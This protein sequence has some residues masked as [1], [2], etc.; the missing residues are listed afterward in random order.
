MPEYL[1]VYGTLRR[2]TGSEMHRLLAR[3]ADL[4]GGAS[5]QGQMY[6]LSYYPGAVPSDNPAHQVKGEV[7]SLQDVESVLP[8]LDEYEE[9]GPGFAAPTE[10]A[11]VRQKVALDDGR[12]LE[13]WVYVYSRPTEGLPEITSGDFLST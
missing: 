4:I 6:R 1:F 5:Y 9:C 13:A 2:G 12:E 8:R 11:R 3:H 10:Y 7:Y